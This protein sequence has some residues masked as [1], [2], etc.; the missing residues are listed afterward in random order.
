MNPATDR[1]LIRIKDVYL[2]IR[3]NGK[4]TTEAVAEEFNIS[5]RTA[6]RD[7]N[8]LEYNELIK[9]SVR[10][11]WTTTSKKVKLSS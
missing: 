6:Q 4:V 8:V 1:M 9:S 11:E 10:G 3:D 2:F 7:L 5:P